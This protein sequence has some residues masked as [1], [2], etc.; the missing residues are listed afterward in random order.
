MRVRWGYRF[1]ENRPTPSTTSEVRPNFDSRR[2]HRTVLPRRKATSFNGRET[3]E[4][5][6]ILPQHRSASVRPTYRWRGAD[7]PLLV[8]ATAPR[9]LPAFAAQ[10]P[11]L[12]P[13]HLLPVGRP[14]LEFAA[15]PVP[16]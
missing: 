7:F 10:A 16:P 14:R 8:G 15:G 9:L 11:S 3:E 12:Q 4:T 1:G 6:L 13:P 2:V 5:E